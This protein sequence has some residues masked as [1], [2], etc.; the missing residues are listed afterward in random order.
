VPFP[1][2]FARL[3]ALQAAVRHSNTLILPT[4]PSLPDWGELVRRGERL[5]G[6]DSVRL[7]DETS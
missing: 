2:A 3:N 6:E 4:F 5:D 7:G 1:F